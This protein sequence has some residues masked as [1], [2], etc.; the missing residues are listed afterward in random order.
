MTDRFSFRRLE[1][2]CG[3]YH[4]RMLIQWLWSAIAIVLIYAMG[5]L[6]VA[7]ESTSVISMAIM[8]VSYPVILSP[9]LFGGRD[10]TL[11][12]QLPVSTA[13]RC[14]FMLGYC[15]VVFPLMAFMLWLL[16][17]SLFRAMC[18]TSLW[19]YYSNVI[20]NLDI[21]GIF[22][23]KSY[24]IVIVRYFNDIWPTLLCL[25]VILSTRRRRMLKGALAVVASVFATGLT[26]GIAG[27][28]MAINE[29]SVLKEI[30]D[31]EDDLAN[32]IIRGMS[33]TISTWSLYL[34]ITLSVLFLILVCLKTARRRI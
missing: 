23:H 29:M 16:L 31:N 5:M 13:E 2:L 34:C 17:E 33:D 30:P 24:I 10:R 19:E 32:E 20:H 11:E 18:G 21:I 26:A 8:F 3:F 28:I 9:F 1:L 25:L 15:M 27:F 14:V 12:L 6:G 4:R 22:E 7:G